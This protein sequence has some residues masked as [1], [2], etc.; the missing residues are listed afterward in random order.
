VTLPPKQPV[1]KSPPV[2]SHIKANTYF[3]IGDFPPQ[4]RRGLRGDGAGVCARRGGSQLGQSTPPAALVL[5]IDRKA[6]A[7]R[8]TP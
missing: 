7:H 4:N 1:S 6:M 3:H 2:C 5:Y 8:P